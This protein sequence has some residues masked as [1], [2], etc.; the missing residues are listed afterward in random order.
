M[1][2]IWSSPRQAFNIFKA[3]VRGTWYII[4]YRITQKDVVIR[5]P[6]YVY[7]K[8]EIS[9]PGK[10][11]IDKGC[12]T[13][14]NNFYHLSINTLNKDAVVYIGRKCGLS[15]LTIRCGDKVVIGDRSIMA[16]TLIQDVIMVTDSVAGKVGVSPDIHI[17]SDVWI[18]GNAFVLPGSNVGDR[19]VIGSNGLIYNRNIPADSFAGGNPVQRP[20]PINKLLKLLSSTTT[21]CHSQP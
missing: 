1:S 14:W 16:A 21:T 11:F 20:L 10:V 17:G 6:F 5:F 13:G 18:A 3:I 19:C 12:S 9:G 15:G 4:Y 7:A 2:K 8:V